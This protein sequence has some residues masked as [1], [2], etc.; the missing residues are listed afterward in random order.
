MI[1]SKVSFSKP[2]AKWSFPMGFMTAHWQLTHSQNDMCE[3]LQL[4]SW[5]LDVYFWFSLCHGMKCIFQVH[6]KSELFNHCTL[7]C[8]DDSNQFQLSFVRCYKNPHS[9]ILIISQVGQF[10]PWIL[11]C[12]V[13]IWLF[14]LTIFDEI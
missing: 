12:T 5:P 6:F 11:N 14:A 9:K 13:E 1:I 8:Y 7:T 10:C 2:R 4:V 3:L